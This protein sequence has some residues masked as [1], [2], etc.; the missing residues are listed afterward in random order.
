MDLMKMAA[1][2]FADK[3]GAGDLDIGTIAGALK[4]L[5]PSDGGDLDIA[6]LV[7]KFSSE[8]G[9]ASLASS[10]LG[11]GNNEAL[12]VS[13]L[14]SVLGEDKV[15]QFAGSLGMDSGTAANGLSEM[16]PD[17]INQGSSGGELLK[18][19]AGSLGKKFLGG[20]F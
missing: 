6:S 13:N 3:V 20:L 1:Q 17:L 4:N 7:S 15:S 11:D 2:L 19:V 16:I 8:G 14:M 10:W 18:D 9:L 5:L 12:S